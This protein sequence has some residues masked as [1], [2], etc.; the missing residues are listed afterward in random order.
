MFWGKFSFL[1]QSERMTKNCASNGSPWISHQVDTP[2]T[3]SWSPVAI[4]P[5][6]CHSSTTVW[7]WCWRWFRS[8]HKSIQHS[9]VV[10]C[11]RGG[12]CDFPE[13][14]REL[15]RQHWNTECGGLRHCSNRLGNPLLSPGTWRLKRWVSG[16]SDSGFTCRSR[17][18]HGW[19][20][21]LSGRKPVRTLQGS[22]S[23]TCTLHGPLTLVAWEKEPSWL[24]F[25]K[26]KG[27]EMM[28]VQ[29]LIAEG[30]LWS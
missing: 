19:Y 29:S 3:A 22:Q 24:T 26:V 11:H 6:S 2:D 9:H 10:D 23:V 15:W 16:S 5:P 18:G 14:K 21:C 28:L 27:D 17:R 30:F 20:R 25:H 4:L 1:C 7:L 8:Q 12:K 13:M